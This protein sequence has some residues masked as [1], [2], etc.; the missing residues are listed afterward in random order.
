MKLIIA[1]FRYY[2]SPAAKADIVI[3]PYVMSVITG[4]LLGDSW[5]T[6]PSSTSQSASGVQQKEFGFVQFLWGIFKPLG[7]VN[8]TPYTQKRFDKRTGN[9]YTNHGFLTVILPFFAELFLEWYSIVNGYSIKHLPT[10]IFELLT[11]VAI[12]FW[13]ASDGS[14]NNV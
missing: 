11:P 2:L 10:N 9:T 6:K 3:P 4:I 5:L 1:L 13:I 8:A 7:L 14:Y 12:A